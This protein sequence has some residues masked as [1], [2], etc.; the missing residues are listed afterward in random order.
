MQFHTP[1]HPKY[2]LRRCFWHI[3]GRVQIH[4]QQVFGCLGHLLLII[5]RNM[6]WLEPYSLSGYYAQML[7]W[8]RVFGNPWSLGCVLDAVSSLLQKKPFGS[9]WRIC[10]IFQPRLLQILEWDCSWTN[11][12]RR[13]WLSMLGTG[14]PE[15]NPWEPPWLAKWVLPSYNIYMCISTWKSQPNM[16][17]EFLFFADLNHQVVGSLFS[18]SWVQQI[19]PPETHSSYARTDFFRVLQHQNLTD[20]ENWNLDI[21]LLLTVWNRINRWNSKI[22][23]EMWERKKSFRIPL[24]ESGE[25]RKSGTLPVLNR[26]TTP[27]TG[28]FCPSYPSIFLFSD[29]G[30]KGPYYLKYAKVKLPEI[31]QGVSPWTFK[32][33]MIVSLFK[34]MG[35]LRVPPSHQT[36]RNSAANPADLFDLLQWLNVT[37]TLPFL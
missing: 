6:G 36:P 11:F 27:L 25:G 2:F 33:V 12:W 4:S 20:P 23:E 28:V 10:S 7:V 34:I 16:M 14:V 19:Y 13:I 17:V 8:W 32:L 35:N 15:K 37:K 3:W 24:V 26:V 31:S 29:F 22:Q 18:N 1:R 9:I 21:S 5:F 30:I